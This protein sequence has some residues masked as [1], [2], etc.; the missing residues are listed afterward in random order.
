MHATDL[1]QIQKISLGTT[2]FTC[3]HGC[4]RIGRRKL[5]SKLTNLPTITM[6]KHRMEEIGPIPITF[7]HFRR[8]CCR[9]WHQTLTN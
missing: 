4:V 9:L 8:I 2:P 1:T 7:Y 5:Y 3:C 6:G